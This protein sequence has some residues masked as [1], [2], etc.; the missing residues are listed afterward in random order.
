MNKTTMILMT[1]MMIGGATMYVACD[2]ASAADSAIP[3]AVPTPS[4]DPAPASDYA[5]Q[6]VARNMYDA[7][8]A[9]R[10]FIAL[11]GLLML[12]VWGVRQFLA[13]RWDWFKTQTGGRVLAF[14]AALLT[15]LGT[16]LVADQP[17]NL[18][19]FVGALTMAWTAAG[20]WHDVKDVK[21]NQKYRA[22]TAPGKTKV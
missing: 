2:E 20:Q 3:N 5:P 15:A 1:M 10:W 12:F 8:R 11:G 19:L 22:D 4:V 17:P 7:I 21:S 13:P 18:S 16:A 9:G 6:D 14:G